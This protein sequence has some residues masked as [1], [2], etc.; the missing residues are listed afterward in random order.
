MLLPA[1]AGPLPDLSEEP[2]PLAAQLATR[3]AVQGRPTRGTA[4]LAA[5]CRCSTSSREGTGGLRLAA[6][7]GAHLRLQETQGREGLFL[8]QPLLGRVVSAGIAAL[9][10]YSENALLTRQANLQ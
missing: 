2:N 3:E 10:L 6:I 5:M 7:L 8:D 1:N 4:A 9:E